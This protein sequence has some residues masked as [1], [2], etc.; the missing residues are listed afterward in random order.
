MGYDD[1][2]GL[3]DTGKIPVAQMRQSPRSEFRF[4]FER[5]ERG[6]FLIIDRWRRDDAD[7]DDDWEF[8]G[9]LLTLP[10]HKMHVLATAVGTAYATAK[11]EGYCE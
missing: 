11:R 1:M 4:Y 10:A 9:P 5:R 3:M 6:T 8:A 2:G 7:D